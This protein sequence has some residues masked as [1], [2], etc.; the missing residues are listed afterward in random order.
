MVILVFRI[1]EIDFRAGLMNW[2]SSVFREKM[3]DMMGEVSS[4]IHATEAVCPAST[5]TAKH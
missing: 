1:A 5:H 2:P 3:E 4:R